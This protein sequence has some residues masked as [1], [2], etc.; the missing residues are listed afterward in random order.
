MV[1]TKTALGAQGI[2]RLDQI[3]QVVAVITDTLSHD[4]KPKCALLF[5]PNTIIPEYLGAKH[6]SLKDNIKS[7]MFI[8]CPYTTMSLFNS[9]VFIFSFP[10]SFHCEIC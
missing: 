3:L 4:S 10:L 1:E 2:R 6:D 5:P 9:F 8:L 7:D